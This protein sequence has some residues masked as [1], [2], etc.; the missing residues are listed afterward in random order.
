MTFSIVLDTCTLYPNYLRDTMLRLANAGC[1]RPLWSRQILG[2]LECSLS[3]HAGVESAERITQ[4]MQRSFPD[5]T[6]T[7]YER[8]IPA[9]GN[10]K[11]DRHVLAA[12]V[13]A[14]ASAIVTFNTSD[15]PAHTVARYEIDVIG[16]DAFLLDQLDRV[17]TLVIDTMQQQVDG[18][19]QP[20]MGLLDLAAALA[21]SGCHDTAGD[22][23]RRIART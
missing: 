13:R 3:A 8:L 17:T 15:F 20:T 10:H 9:M 22:L 4:L 23:R 5:A 21:T 19:R 14:N 7:G 6:V 2:E 11:K 18:Y 1:F 12:A 16:P